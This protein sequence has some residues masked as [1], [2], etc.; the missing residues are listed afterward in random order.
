VRLTIN[1]Q[2][3]D[4]V[5]EANKL[6]LLGEVSPG[7]GWRTNIRHLASP[8]AFFNYLQGIMAEP[9]QNTVTIN[10]QPRLV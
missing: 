10:W 7:E 4:F 8:Q 1:H 2:A 6:F 3:Q 5:Q 9:N